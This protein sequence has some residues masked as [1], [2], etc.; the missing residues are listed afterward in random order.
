MQTLTK[1]VRCDAADVGGFANQYRLDDI[2][3]R[4]RKA[5]EVEAPTGRTTLGVLR[6]LSVDR[7]DWY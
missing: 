3:R 4:D 6:V 2:R 7:I 5:A 1:R